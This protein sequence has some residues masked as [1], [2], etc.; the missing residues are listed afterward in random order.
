MLKHNCIKCGVAYEDEDED[1]YLCSVCKTEKQ[2]LAKQI[3]ARIGTTIGQQPK[4]ELNMFNEI[5]HSKGGKNNNFV[6]VRD[7]GITP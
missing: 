5:A 6:N 3:D 1:A 2:S 7:L 4:S